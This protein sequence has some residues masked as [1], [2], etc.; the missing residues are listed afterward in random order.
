MMLLF[1][2]KHIE[3]VAIGNMYICLET[4]FAFVPFKMSLM[5]YLICNIIWKLVL[6]MV[7]A[8]LV[9]WVISAIDY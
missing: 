7:A 5:A 4:K 2:V 3:K 1:F 6:L 8:G 9:C